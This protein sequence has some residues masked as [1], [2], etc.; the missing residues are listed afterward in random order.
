MRAASPDRV[1]AAGAAWRRGGLETIAR[2][3]VGASLTRAHIEDLLDQAEGAAQAS[4]AELTRVLG[5]RA[6]E[7]YVREFALR[8]EEVGQAWPLPYFALYDG[9]ARVIELNTTLIAEVESHLRAMG[10]E[11]LVGEGLLRQVAVAHELHHHLCRIP[12]QPRSLVR[13]WRERSTA[14]VRELLEELAAERFS[15]LLVGIGHAPQDYV[16]AAAQW[17]RTRGEGGT[18]AGGAAGGPPHSGLMWPRP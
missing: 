3:S 15:Q 12:G 10:R 1:D 13:R 8:V 14:K 18:S 4:F 7:D 6:P 11:D 17:V 9:D 2:S 16:Q 5:L